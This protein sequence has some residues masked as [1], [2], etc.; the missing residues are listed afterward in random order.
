MRRIISGL[1]ASLLL[2]CSVSS[3]AN[4]LQLLPLVPDH[5]GLTIK[6]YPS[7][8]WI[9]VNKPTAGARM[10]LTLVD[11][12]T[13]KPIF[14][15]QLPSSF[16]TEKNELCQCVNLKDY[17]IQLEPDIQYRWFISINQNPESHSQDIVAGGVIERC[18]FE[19]CLMV[20][21]MPS[22]CGMDSVNTLARS[23]FR[24]D[25]ISCLCDLIK[26]NPDNKTLRRM[27]HSLMKQGGLRHTEPDYLIP[28]ES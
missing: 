18:S 28:L 23:G 19:E 10:M 2:I 11:S 15:G 16:L 7:L 8:C 6:K 26:S 21:D 13:I 20:L 14:E 17:D 5:V 1:L 27:L 12:R 9:R 4:E 25:S 24:Y 22:G 3:R